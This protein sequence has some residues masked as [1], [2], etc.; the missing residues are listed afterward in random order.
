MIRF[1]SLN[2]CL[3][4]AVRGLDISADFDDDT[5][6]QLVTAFCDKRL[7]VITDQVCDKQVYRNFALR[8]GTPIPHVLDHL[9]MPGY[10][11]MMAIGNMEQKDRSDAVR[12]GAALWHTDQSYEAVPAS[13]TM[14]YCRKAPEVGGETMFADMVTAYEG[15]AARMR[16]RI[17]S[18]MVGHLYGAGR[19]REDET[20]SSPLVNDDQARRVP[21]AFHPLV[22]PHP[23]TGRKALYAVAHTAY[24]IK[25]MADRQA[26]LL[27][28][29][30]KEHV[31]Q[32][33]YIYEHRHKVGDIAIYDTLA[34]MHSA[35]P[36]DV[37]AGPDTA[38]LLW[39]ISVR[40]R[41][42]D[43]VYQDSRN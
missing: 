14:L 10:P 22:M 4:M 20:G 13:A 35:K 17:D 37:V 7:I 33:K 24:R 11:D 1:E 30:L 39:R 18:L 28:D 15:L 16:Q 43:L 42:K 21:T 8:W 19:L 23:I 29:E 9:R 40:G 31:L 34:T 38:R 32:K 27:L 6:R 5:M 3:G 41:P 25:A 26:Q 12:N 36:I 2:G